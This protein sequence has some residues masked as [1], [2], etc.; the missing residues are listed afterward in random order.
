MSPRERPCQR[1]QR[2]R[3]PD[4]AAWGRAGPTHQG[5]LS[6]GAG[7]PLLLPRVDKPRE[8]QAPTGD[9]IYEGQGREVGR[10]AWPWLGTERQQTA[11]AG[12][13]APAPP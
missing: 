12:T 8:V 7:G 4:R 10:G 11:G 13:E 3:N 1:W 9:F 5:E 6:K 2:K